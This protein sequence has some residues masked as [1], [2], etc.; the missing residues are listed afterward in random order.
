MSAYTLVVVDDHPVMRSGLRNMLDSNDDLD[1]LAEADSGEK[2]IRLVEQYDPDVLLLDVEMPNMTGVDV[3]RALKESGARTRILAL[4][5]YDDKSYVDALLKNG[6][7]GYIT[8]D[9]P[10]ALIAEAVRAVARGEGR[11]FVTPGVQKK[12]EY[13]ISDREQDVLKLMAS[14]CSN[15]QIAEQLFISKNTVR[16]HIANIYD[17]LQINS[18]REAVAWA[19]RDGL[20][21]RD[22]Q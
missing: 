8:K 12:E 4:S 16:N 15:S 9:K 10:M 18:W 17:K 20:M 11:W 1:V 22:E 19:W 7:A 6:A 2:A 13:P 5:A 21:E 14:G 3:A